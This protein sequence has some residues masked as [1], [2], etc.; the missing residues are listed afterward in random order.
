MLFKNSGIGL[1]FFLIISIVASLS[2]LQSFWKNTGFLY[3]FIIVYRWLNAFAKIAVFAIAMQFCSKK[4]SA[5][6]FTFYMTIGAMGSLAGA[7][8]IGPIKANF[9][10]EI[11]FS[12]FI[13]MLGLAWFT[14]QFL[15]IEKH[16]EQIAEL[17]DEEVE[18]EK[19]VLS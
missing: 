10:W 12:S 15:N 11:T 16:L 8:L 2:I 1:Y 9:G 17:E 13:V 18:M 7:T 14:M 19:L 4:V 5:S 6:Q 3:G